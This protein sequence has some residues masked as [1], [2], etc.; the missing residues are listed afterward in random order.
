MTQPPTPPAASSS[1]A[2]IVMQGNRSKNTSPELALRRELHRRGRRYRLHLSPLPGLRCT[3]DLVF[4][5]ARVV[6]FV[7]GCFWHRRPLHATTPKANA[8]FWRKKFQAN[9]A[10]DARNKKAL[11][12]AG[13]HVVVIWEHDD[14]WSAADLVEAALSYGRR[15]R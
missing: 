7:N 4:F 13:W 1:A 8:A 2:R 10:R 12:A 6:V 15:D 14:A 3:P 9:I 5:G 11:E